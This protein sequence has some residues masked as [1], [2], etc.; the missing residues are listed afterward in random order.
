M[1]D[2]P[3]FLIGSEAEK[4]GTIRHGKARDFLGFREMGNWR[5]YALGRDQSPPEV[6]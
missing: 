6:P 1:A 4:A 3:G 5:K 2:I